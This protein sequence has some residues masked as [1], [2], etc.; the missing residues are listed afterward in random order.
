VAGEVFKA[1]YFLIIKTN[2]VET[3]T[4]EQIESAHKRAG[5]DLGNMLAFLEGNRPTDLK[6]WVKTLADVCEAAGRNVSDFDIPEDGTDEEKRDAYKKRLDL[7]ELIFNGGKNC[8]QLD[9]SKYRY[10]I[11]ANIIQDKKARFGFRLDF[12]GY[13]RA[14]VNSFLGAR[15]EFHTEADA[16]YVFATFT[17][18][19]EGFLYYNNLCKLKSK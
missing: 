12:G 3:F 8:D 7:Y 9:P 16:K 5:G 18:D 19:H 13:V 10:S 1:N 4:K 15:H 2:K 14:R 6:Q 11:W 17:E